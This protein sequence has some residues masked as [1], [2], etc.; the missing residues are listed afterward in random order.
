MGKIGLILEGGGMRGMYTTGVLDFFMEK[1]LYFPYVIG[2]SAGAMNGLS[3]VSKQKG[4]NRNITM[5]FI[6]DSRYVNMRNIFLGR[7]V[8]GLDFIF[9]DIC[10]KYNPFDYK[11]FME[12]DQNFN[13][14]CTDVE[15]GEPVYYDKGSCDDILTAC[16]ASSSLP[17]VNSIVEFEGRKLLDGGLSDPIPYK[18]AIRDGY[19][20]NV[21][22]LTRD[23]DFEVE[24]VKHKL[25]LNTQY[26]E[27]PNLLKTIFERPVNYERTLSD[28][29]N[30]EKSKDFFVIRPSEPINIKIF[31]SNIKDLIYIY[32]RGYIDAEKKYKD[33]LEWI[34]DNK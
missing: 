22:V 31:D 25:I 24:P 28:I 19:C 8:F 33:L 14:A 11:T 34:D 23:E 12:S 13:L 16:K 6:S 18:K 2:V 27:Y 32:I 29:K 3:Y 30:L 21:I 10:K 1:N 15:T 4:R 5:E 26:G 7:D 9:E 20:K 17:L